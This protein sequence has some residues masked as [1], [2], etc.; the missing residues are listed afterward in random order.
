MVIF[1]QV[2]AP[3]T[4]SKPMALIAAKT[5]ASVILIDCY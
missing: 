4:A 2:I 5:S 3:S 1:Y